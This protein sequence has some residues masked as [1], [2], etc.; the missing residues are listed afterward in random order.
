MRFALE[1]LPVVAL[2]PYEGLLRGAVVA[3]KR[4][5]RAYAAAFGALLRARVALPARTLLVPVT[6]TPARRAARGFD[7]AKLLAQ[8]YA[9]TSVLDCLR[10]NGGPAQHGRT[11]RERLAARDLYRVDG[12]VAGRR[13]VL[14]DDVCTTGATLRAAAEALRA[15]GAEVGGALVLARATL[16]S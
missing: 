13:V 12:G 2:G 6:T 1:G 9:A 16:P 5:E 8:A 15:A 7:Q 14:L 10:K 3:F 4:G 11:R